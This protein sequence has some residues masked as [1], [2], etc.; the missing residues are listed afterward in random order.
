MSVLNSLVSRDTEGTAMVELKSVGDASASNIAG[1]R[2]P[3]GKSSSS[4]GRNDAT[5]FMVENIG[6]LL[7]H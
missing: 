2:S 7:Q 6:V 5:L 1:K 3:A 4:I